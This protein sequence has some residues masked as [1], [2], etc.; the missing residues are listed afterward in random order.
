M[1]LT[2]QIIDAITAW[3]QTVATALTGA[4]FAAVGQL[5]FSTP[6][7]D[8]IPEVQATWSLVQA[9]ADSL[10]G[11][12]I[13][14]AGILVM[15]SGT[16][17]SRYS[18]KLLIS[19]LALAAIGANASLALSG[20]LIRLDNALVVGLL[21]SDPAARTVSE[22]AD[23]IQSAHPVN[24]Y[25]TILVALWAAFLALFLVAL[26]IGR[27]LALL[28]AIVA[29][30]LAVATYALPQT[31]EIARLWVRAFVALL[32]VQVVQAVLVLI[33]L[34]LLRRTDWLGGAVSDLISGLMLIALLYLLFKLPFA[35]FH[36]AFRQG[37]R[38]IPLVQPLVV[39][40]RVTRATF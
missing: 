25:V 27:D 8:Q 29:A 14:C 17:E 5:L 28:V 39:A 36:W 16:V 1:D 9:I 4:A 37:V 18:A 11:L 30:P 2:A 31:D 10:F 38:E 35:A 34:Q 22:L 6:A 20:A 13:L 19:R 33:G 12:A 7:L 3:L 40:A 21:G 23:I 15:A 24:Q 26:Y 32:F